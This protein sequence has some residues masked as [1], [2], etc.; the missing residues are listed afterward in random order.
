M[1]RR[2]R[3]RVGREALSLC[4]GDAAAHV[5]GHCRGRLLVRGRG[6]CALLLVVIQ[7]LRL[8]GRR[9]LLA[10]LRRVLL[11]VV[12]RVGHGGQRAPEGVRRLDEFIGASSGNGSFQQAQCD[13][14]RERWIGSRSGGR[15]AARV[16]VCDVSVGRRRRQ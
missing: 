14:G 4:G 13:D 3:R 10:M 15:R 8:H 1:I 12:V 6:E 16:A 7:I 5:G 2:G 11:V 9:R